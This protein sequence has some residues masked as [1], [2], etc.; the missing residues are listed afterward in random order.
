MYIAIRMSKVEQFQSMANVKARSDAPN[1][2]VMSSGITAIKRQLDEVQNT[3]IDYGVSTREVAPVVAQTSQATP[4]QNELDKIIRTVSALTQQV[5]TIYDA[6][7]SQQCIEED[8]TSDFITPS[9]P[10]VAFIAHRPTFSRTIPITRKVKPLPAA[11]AQ[12]ATP[13]PTKKILG[14]VMKSV[15][16]VAAPV[17]DDNNDVIS[18]E[19]IH[20]PTHFTD[21][22]IKDAHTALDI[23]IARK[24]NAET[25]MDFVV[26]TE[27]ELYCIRRFRHLMASRHEE[28]AKN[29]IR[30]FDKVCGKK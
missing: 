29:F 18:E 9:P 24:Y 16:A 5:G 15:G 2:Q 13:P 28:L 7:A 1:M 30:Q 6:V 4:K 23:T 20:T 21:A 17:D 14:K 22:Q 25:P 8:D 26:G 27:E 11:P 12:V 19:E 3:L 10:Q